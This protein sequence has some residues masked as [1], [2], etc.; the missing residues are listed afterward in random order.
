VHLVGSYTNGTLLSRST[1]SPRLDTLNVRKVLQREKEE[2]EEHSI[3]LDYTNSAML[4]S[5]QKNLDDITSR[6]AKLSQ[7]FT[8]ANGNQFP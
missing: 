7:L 2:N 3:H 4:S 5:L 6:L 1:T 8:T